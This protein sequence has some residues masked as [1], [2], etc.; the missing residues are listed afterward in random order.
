MKKQ[1]RATAADKKNEAAI[2]GMVLAAF[3]RHAADLNEETKVKAL[4]LTR[5]YFGEKSDTTG[6]GFTLM[7]GFL[8][9]LSAGMEIAAAIEAAAAE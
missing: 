1:I 8:M 4:Q 9:G 6:A 3:D 7:S 5:A 2:D